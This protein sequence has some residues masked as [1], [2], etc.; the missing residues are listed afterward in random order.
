MFRTTE[1][2]SAD[3]KFPSRKFPS[4][5]NTLSRKARFFF[6]LLCVAAG[7]LPVLAAF[8]IGPQGRAAINGPAWLGAAAGGVFIIAGIALLLGEDGSRSDHPMSYVLLACALGAFAAVANW[9][10]F[11]PG[12]REC[13][14]AM[15]GI[16]FEPGS[17]GNGIACRAGFGIGAGILDGFLLWLAA[18]AA[19]KFG[20]PGGIATALERLGLVVLGLSLAPIALPLFL[21]LVGKSLIGAFL[22]WC[23][24]GKWPRN[25]AFIA[26][27]KARR[28]AK[29]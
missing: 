1:L 4:R 16:A 22:A 13:T 25:E 26:R 21:F 10:A 12:P 20:A 19:Q 6:G 14:V 23:R 17:P 28:A 8:D 18:G 11:G 29:R 7:L 3:F 5:H 24:T 2:K 9:I 15:V 27:M